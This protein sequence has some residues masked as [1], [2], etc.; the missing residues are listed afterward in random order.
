MLLSEASNSTPQLRQRREVV[1]CLVVLAGIIVGGTIGF[2]YTEGHWSVWD[3]LYF[4]LIT[5]TTVGYGDDGLSPAGRILAILLVLFGIGTATYTL[6]VLVQLAVGY[7]LSWK[8]K[9]KQQIN[10]LEQHVLVCGFGRL[11]R[12]ACERL[13][14]LQSPFVVIEENESEFQAAIDQGYLALRGCATKDDVL[15][16]AA[17]ER[18]RGVICGVNSDAENVFITLSARELNPNVFIVSRADA[19]DAHAKLKRAGA[20]LVVSPHSTAASNIV[21]SI[22]CPNLTKFL[23][24]SHESSGRFELSEVTIQEG[25]ILI[26]RTVSQYGKIEDS[27]SFVAIVRATGETVM[28]PDGDDTFQCGDVVIV[29]GYS[30]DSARMNELA[31]SPGADELEMSSSSGRLLEA[32]PLATTP[33]REPLRPQAPDHL[34]SMGVQEE[35]QSCTE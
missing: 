19:N 7:Q 6:S 1:T 22:L 35:L 4:T 23:K 12:A 8:L 21:N 17:I 32:P 3:A 13:R 25:S 28:K 14:A 5:V 31:N 16:L 10:Q 18:A 29:A 9:M 34:Q 30:Q 15:R 27:I 33:Q 24:S 26:G 20:S 11:G 2:T